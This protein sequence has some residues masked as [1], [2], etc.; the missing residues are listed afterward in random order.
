[1]KR[2]LGFLGTMLSLLA[3]CF[4][5]SC[6]NGSEFVGVLNLTSKKTEITANAEFDKNDKLVNKTAKALVRLY[7]NNDE[8]T[9]KQYKDLS[10]TNG[11]SGSVTF[12][13]LTADTDYIARL[14]VTYDGKEYEITSKE[15][16]TKAAGTTKNEATE[17]TTADEF[18]AMG[19]EPSGYYVLKNDID[20]GGRNISL[21]STSSDAFTG[22]FDGDNH[23]ISNFSLSATAYS[24]IFGYI[25]GADIKNL[26]IDFSKANAATSFSLT[27]T[28]K[29]FGVLAGYAT[30]SN[31]ENVVITSANIKSTSFSTSDTNIG[32]FVGAVSNT[33]VSN[34]K[35]E[36]SYLTIDSISPSTSYAS[37]L[38]GFIGSAEGA[39]KIVSS[40][41]AAELEI[42]YT[43][44][45]GTKA[46]S[47]ALGGFIGLNK[48]SNLISDSY[49]QGNIIVTRNS[50]VAPVTGSA[51]FVGGFIGR[52]L[53]GPCNLDGCLANVN[54][55]ASDIK[56]EAKYSLASEA[57]IGGLIGFANFSTYGIKN[58]LY[59]PYK[60]SE[61][62]ENVGINIKCLVEKLTD[63]KTNYNYSFSLTIGTASTNKIENIYSYNDLLSYAQQPADTEDKS[64]IAD[65]AIQYVIKNS[66]IFNKDLENILSEELIKVIP[67][68]SIDLKN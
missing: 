6:S 14:F 2:I 20:F 58:S 27:S 4:I 29:H 16:K 64:G 56:G 51:L 25:N 31:I 54:I 3:L 52:S 55:L 59:I 40:G 44:S 12:S 41:S 22:T 67:Q 42:K 7:E 26:N 19:E 50:S 60:N 53:G 18:I 35:V 62:A 37:N 49:S 5:T 23:T 48:S 45:T 8:K 47:I 21:C 38:G 32:L 10:L 30:E 28:V 39:S 24:G 36:N 17:I 68:L 1:M 61:Q 66:E 46:G 9:Y 57:Y 34:S 65:E 63:D 15:I 11:I 43:F 33:N 13:S